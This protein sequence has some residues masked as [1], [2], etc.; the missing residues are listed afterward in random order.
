[1]Q[2]A[3]FFFPAWLST[4]VLTGLTLGCGSTSSNGGGDFECPKD[5]IAVENQEFCAAHAIETDCNL[6]TPAYTSQMCGVPL[7][8][9]PAEL[10]RSDGVM[11]YAGS[12][13]P[14]VSCMSPAGY[15]APAGAPQ[16]VTVTGIAEIF[17]HGCESKDVTIEFHRVNRTGGP[18]DGNLGPV[19]GTP[20]TTASD[21]K[22]DGLVSE[23]DTCGMRYECKYSYAGVPTETE[24][25]IKTD[26]VLWAPLYEYNIYI[27]N[28][29]VTNGTW[30]HDV[31]AIAQDDYTVIA[32]AAIGT[33]ITASHGAVAGEVHDCEDVRLINAVVDVDADKRIT[34]Y[35]T[36]DEEHPLPDLAAKG[37]SAL[38]LYS[39]MDIK[40]GPV[41]VAAG[42]LVG[43]KVVALGFYRAWV[44][45]DSITSVTF[46]G[47]RPFQL[48]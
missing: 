48:P 40:A 26:G 36:N 12:G 46:R 2:R 21:C 22:I 34:T 15:P 16:D 44:F 10:L 47:L 33:P 27:P 39:A 35:F 38:G 45:E 4:L 28:D 14:S 9:P 17:S 29:A 37:T 43:G 13:T 19:V 3:C 25:A 5:L 8:N 42:G 23:V 30:A 1:M 31:R 32:Q 7:R 24:L 18:D 6:V 20:V 41:T 11:K